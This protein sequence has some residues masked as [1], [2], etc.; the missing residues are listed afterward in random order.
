MT[1]NRRTMTFALGCWVVALLAPSTVAHADG[2]EL[3]VVMA[4]NS[5]VTGMTFHELKQLYMG[6]RMKTPAGDWMVPLNRRADDA[7]RIGFDDSVLGMGPETVRQYWIDRKIRG[8]SGPPKTINGSALIVKLV[9]KVPGAIGY[10]RLSEAQ[11]VKV[12]KIDGKRPGESGYGI[13][14]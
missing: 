7:E 6:Q 8:Q 1:I 13:R 11:G 4:E 9:N 14:F 5:S 2:N 10:V 12:L 3:A